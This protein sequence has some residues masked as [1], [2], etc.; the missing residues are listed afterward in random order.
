MTPKDLDLDSSALP[1]DG[2]VTKHKADWLLDLEQQSWQAELLVSGIAI[3]STLKLPG[4][5]HQL[6]DLLLALLPNEMMGW[7]PFYT[8]WY[9]MI[10]ASGLIISFIYHF[11]LRS[12]WIGLIGFN[13]VYPKGILWSTKLFSQAMIKKMRPEYSNIDD[14]ISKLDNHASGIF[15]G[16]F[17]FAM[18]MFG[19]TALLFV[20][21]ILA[22]GLSRILPFGVKQITIVIATIFGVLVFLNLLLG[23]K[24]LRDRP[25]VVKVHYPIIKANSFLVFS[26]LR[27]SMDYII[28]T[29]RTNADNSTKFFVQLFMAMFLTMIVAIPMLASSNSDLFFEHGFVSNRSQDNV[30]YED[31]YLNQRASSARILFPIIPSFDIH[32]HALPVFIPTLNRENNALA[33]IADDWEKNEELSR[34]ENRI[35]RTNYEL[36][37]LRKY[38][39]FWINGSKIENIAM[40]QHTHSNAGEDGVLVIVPTQ[41]FVL[42]ENVLQIQ[43]AYQY[44]DEND[45]NIDMVEMY[46]RFLF[47]G[48]NTIP[49]S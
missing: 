42:G 41:Q 3:F 40:Y 18:M 17:W 22:F 47:S 43:Q 6:T 37:R 11:I 21:L 33:E 13:S 9:L 30:I 31:A 15:A 39:S 14:L 4:L 23:A 35:A 44:K 36:E 16:A 49:N 29:I 24:W 34:V 19:Y 25:W 2:H 10:G 12:F 32:G 46:I 28:L 1:E 48:R 26:F 8:V 45:E 38:Y 7:F 5:I 27:K 20:I